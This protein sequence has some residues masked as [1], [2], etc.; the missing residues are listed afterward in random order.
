MARPEAP[1]ARPETPVAR[2]ETPVARPQAPIARPQA[3]LARLEASPP[4]SEAVIA[5]QAAVPK[6]APAGVE[7]GLS[8]LDMEMLVARVVTYYEA[9]DL[10]R[11][12]G[13]YDVGS[14]GFWE[15]VRIRH[16]FQEFFSTTRARRLRLT[17]VSWETAALSARAKGMAS[18][19]AEYPD[20]PGG[21]LERNVELELDVIVR[22]GQAR[23]ARLLL[24]PHSR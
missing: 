8:T 16:D 20:Q 7:A 19:S 4:R 11:L 22:D 23:I 18:L 10:D 3:P 24:F 12:L 9:G 13:M 5:A 21:K 14:V 6:A 17:R 2:P 15:A 1:I